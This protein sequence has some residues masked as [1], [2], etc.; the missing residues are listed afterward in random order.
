M[1]WVKITDSLVRQITSIAA[2]AIKKRKRTLPEQ[3]EISHSFEVNERRRPGHEVRHT[4]GESGLNTFCKPNDDRSPVGK[5]AKLR[6]ATNA[7]KFD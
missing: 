2:A 6:Y 3:E 5:T 4:T 1:I 7:P